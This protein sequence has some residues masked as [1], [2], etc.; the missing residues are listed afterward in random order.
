MN[1]VQTNN[2]IGLTSFEIMRKFTTLVNDTVAAAYTGNL[3]ETLKN[4]ISC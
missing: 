4:T 1:T 2:F 3:D